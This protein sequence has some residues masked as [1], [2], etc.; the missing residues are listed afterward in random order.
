MSLTLETALDTPDDSRSAENEGRGSD[1]LWS[2]G[3]TDSEP[4]P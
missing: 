3:S 1:E 4:V 2:L